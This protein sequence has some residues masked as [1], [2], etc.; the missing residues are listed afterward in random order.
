MGSGD[1]GEALSGDW[2]SAGCDGGE[3][4][5]SGFPG[6]TGEGEL[7]SIGG[8]E[9]GGWSRAIGIVGVRGSPEG[10]DGDHLDG[11]SGSRGTSIRS[12]ASGGGVAVGALGGGACGGPGGGGSTAGPLVVPDVG[13]SELVSITGVSDGTEGLAPSVSVGEDRGGEGTPSTGGL[14]GGETG[15]E[16]LGSWGSS[17]GWGGWGGSVGGDLGGGGPDVSAVGGWHPRLVWKWW[18]SWGF[19]WA[20]EGGEGILLGVLLE[21]SDVGIPGGL[22][23]V[24]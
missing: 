15:P 21:D 18:D 19:W 1:T 8:P 23:G 7:E 4:D 17:S 11:V 13:H 24:V 2:R 6:A 12:R 10:N 20:K 5:N 16:L 9:G 14:G 3:P 22:G